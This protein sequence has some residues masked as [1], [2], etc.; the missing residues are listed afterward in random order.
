[1]ARMTMDQRKIL[2]RPDKDA[3]KITNIFP[4]VKHRRSSQV[5]LVLKRKKN[6]LLLNYYRR[7]TAGSRSSSIRV[8][9]GNRILYSAKRRRE[10]WLSSCVVVFSPARSFHCL[11]RRRHLKYSSTRNRRLPYSTLTVLLTILKVNLSIF[12]WISFFL[13]TSMHYLCIIYHWTRENHSHFRQK[14]E[15][16]NPFL[17]LRLDPFFARYWRSAQTIMCFLHNW[18]LSI[19]SVCLRVK[20]INFFLSRNLF[21]LTQHSTQPINN[22]KN[23]LFFRTSLPSLIT[24]I[25]KVIIQCPSL[26]VR[27]KWTRMRI[28]MKRKH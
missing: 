18:S 14:K 21:S 22:E 16:L 12:H 13:C 6:S 4:L 28:V 10:N 26:T 17:E 1:M 24:L 15:N 3:I 5:R 11:G 20:S 23:K 27:R 25:S 7:L 9:Q 2:L 19:R 8:Y